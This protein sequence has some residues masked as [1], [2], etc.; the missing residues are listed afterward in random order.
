MC[1]SII[2]ESLKG[3]DT[4][5]PNLLIAKLNAYGFST[6]NQSLCETLQTKV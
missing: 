1:F 6:K 5:D 2:N 3:F 4:V